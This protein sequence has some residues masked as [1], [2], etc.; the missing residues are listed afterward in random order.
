[1]IV[2]RGKPEKIREGVNMMKSVFSFSI[3]ADRFRVKQM[4]RFYRLCESLQLMIYV[5][6]RS[7]VR[8]TKRLPDFLTILIRDLSMSD[9]CLVVIE[10][11][12]MRQAKQA[13]KRIGGL[14]LQPVPSI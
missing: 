2:D 8:Q 7:T 6:G 14:S 9:K 10:G 13:L 3:R 11:S 12:R 1:L 4:I 5:C